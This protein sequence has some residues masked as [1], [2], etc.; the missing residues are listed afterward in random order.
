MRFPNQ[1][2]VIKEPTVAIKWINGFL[3]L[4]SLQIFTEAQIL[5]IVAT[6][7]SQ[8]FSNCF[9]FA[10]FQLSGPQIYF[11]ILETYLSIE[12]GLNNFSEL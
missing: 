4:A 7:S 1:A 2:R 10:L 12:K 3:A 8:T 11:I 9:S 6:I 5:S